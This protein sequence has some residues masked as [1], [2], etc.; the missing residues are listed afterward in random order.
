M[1]AVASAG[2]FR[3]R[4]NV[5]LRSEMRFKAKF[6]Q[7]LVRALELVERH[8]DSLFPAPHDVAGQMLSLRW[9]G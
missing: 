7:I 1:R 9:Q 8:A 4:R 3:N 5:C 6:S 2:T